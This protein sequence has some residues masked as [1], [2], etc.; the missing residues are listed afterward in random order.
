[1]VGCI[2]VFAVLSEAAVSARPAL[3]L[4]VSNTTTNTI[5]TTTTTIIIVT[6]SA[7]P[8]VSYD[9]LDILQNYSQKTMTETK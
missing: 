2:P 5:T 6:M 3:E 1:M 4:T 7:F 8:A 9:I